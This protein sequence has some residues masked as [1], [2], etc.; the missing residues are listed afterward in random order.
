MTR[1]KSV[2][3][4]SIEYDYDTI[5]RKL[6]SVRKVMI[7]GDEEQ[8]AENLRRAY[9]FALFSVQT[10]KERHEEAY[11][12]WVNGMD[13][14]DALEEAPVVWHNS[15]ADY[16]KITD[17]SVDWKRLASDVRKLAVGGQIREL[18]GMQDG[19]A[20]V[21]YNKWG[22]TLAMAGIWEMVCVDSNV[23]NYFD[24]G[25]RIRFRGKRGLDRYMGARHL[26]SCQAP[27]RPPFL[28]QWMIFDEQRDTYTTHDVFFKSVYP[29]R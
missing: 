13:R 21:N 5:E 29:Y 16:A 12:L 10:P 1:T 6:R 20:G 7:L 27:S 11:R 8:A 23:Q 24:M 28:A 2:S 9:H 19:L 26:I 4:R 3:D 17:E 14:A 22:F 18:A 15:K 25:D